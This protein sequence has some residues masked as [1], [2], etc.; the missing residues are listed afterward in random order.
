M[1]RKSVQALL[2]VDLETD[3]LPEGSSYENVNVL[4]GAFLI[5]DLNLDPLAG[6]HEPL[7]LTPNSVANLKKNDYVREMHMKNGLLKDASKSSVTLEEL[8]EQVIQMIK[9][10]TTFVEGEFGI[11]GSGVA[12]FDHP[13]IK[14]KMPKLA[15]YLAYYPYDIGI[16]RRMTKL[17]AGKPIVNPVLASYGDEKT[18]RAWDDVNA[19]LEEAREYQ[20]VFG[21]KFV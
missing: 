12:A 16:M 1:P 20:R 10:D 18:H 13:L 19:H 21:E 4:E 9:D 5:T 3:G 15:R 17:F 8:E 2:W 6:L 14:E 11:A 7:K